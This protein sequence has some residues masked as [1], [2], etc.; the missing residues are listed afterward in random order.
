MLVLDY[1]EFINQLDLRKK[2][3]MIKIKQSIF[4]S[5]GFKTDKCFVVFL[6]VHRSCLQS[7][8]NK[9]S[10]CDL[11]LYIEVMFTLFLNKH[12]F[13]PLLYYL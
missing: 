5:S 6:C 11:I 7:F 9:P 2:E 13:V 10:G 8:T 4:Y 3:E 12:D 1:E